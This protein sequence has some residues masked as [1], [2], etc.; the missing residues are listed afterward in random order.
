MS[1]E[2]QDQ[3]MDHFAASAPSPEQQASTSETRAL[4]EKA[5]EMLPEI[6]R[7]VF[8][9]RDV[10]EM[11]TSGTATALDITEETVK[12]RLHRARVMLRKQLYEQIGS[13]SKEAFPFHAVRC[14]RV[15][16][17]VFERIGELPRLQVSSGNYIS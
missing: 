1:K 12:T 9:L 17:N 10:E 4:L 2:E 7:T 5:I 15:V 13:S 14:D 16:K 3:P 11:D 6:Y 8:V